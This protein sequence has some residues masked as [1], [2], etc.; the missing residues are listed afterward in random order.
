MLSDEMHDGSV[1]ASGRAVASRRGPF[2]LSFLFTHPRAL[3]LIFLACARQYPRHDLVASAL[4]RLDVQNTPLAG[5]R[6]SRSSATA[7]RAPTLGETATALESGPWPL[8]A[9]AQILDRLGEGPRD[10]QTR[11]RSALAPCRLPT[12]L[13]VEESATAAGSPMRCPG[14]SRADPQ[15]VPGQPTLGSAAR[16]RRASQARHLHFS[17]R[18]FQ[19]H[20][21]PSQA[22]VPDLAELSRQSCR[23]LGVHRLSSRCRP[24]PSGFC[25]F[26]SFSVTIA[27]A[28]SISMSRSILRQ[29]G[30][31]SRSLMLFRGIRRRVTCCETGMESTGRT[32]NGALR[33]STSSRFRRRRA[34]RGRVPTS[35]GSLEAFG[36]SVSHHVI[37]LDERHLRRILRGYVDY[38]HSCRTH[39]SLEK[40]AP[41][42]RPVQWPS[43]G[44]VTAIPKVGGLHHY[45]SR[46]AA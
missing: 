38:Y 25:S 18:C 22:T 2:G 15:H 44:R 28:S 20:D 36:A 43:M 27:G 3:L 7:R 31:R 5:A 24:P 26:S 9:L 33:D 41:E 14:G 37:I 19:V 17:G 21:S 1:P 40:D 35:N 29:S 39:L 8:G 45:Y 4:P 12:L 10:R 11:H 46:L 16:A 32:S 6:E 13:D 23:G 30:P 42:Q 34:P